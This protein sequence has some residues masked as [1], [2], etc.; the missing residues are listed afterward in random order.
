MDIILRR[1]RITLAVLELREIGELQKLEKKWWY[2]LGECGEKG[3]SKK[4]R[5]D[6][7]VHEFSSFQKKK[8]KHCFPVISEKVIF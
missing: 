7:M 3:E 6:G 1:D 8:I 4:V 2:D 5:N